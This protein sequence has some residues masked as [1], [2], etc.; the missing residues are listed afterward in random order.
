[1]GSRNQL[2]SSPQSLPPQGGGEDPTRP[3]S[4]KEA[5]PLKFMQ[6]WHC[7]NR[8]MI[9]TVFELR[10][11]SLPCCPHLG[12]KTVLQGAGPCSWRGQDQHGP[13]GHTPP[14]A[15]APKKERR[16]FQ[17]D[18]FLWMR[19]HALWP[20]SPLLPAPEGAALQPALRPGCTADPSLLHPQGGPSCPPDL[21]GRHLQSPVE[22]GWSPV[23]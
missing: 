21:S 9:S 18:V 5:D 4:P 1:M 14:Q 19:E 12:I 7:F 23:C 3:Q 13:G 17:P 2:L 16:R 10:N 11:F 6:T 8:R 22:S 20:P 15:L